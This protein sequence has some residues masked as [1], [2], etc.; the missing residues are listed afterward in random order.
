[1]LSK[2]AGESRMA[3]ESQSDWRGGFSSGHEALRLNIYSP[4]CMGVAV[5]VRYVPQRAAVICSTRSTNHTAEWENC[6]VIV[7]QR[8]PGMPWGS[9][10][11]NTF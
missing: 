9:D 11:V 1:M 3:G 7:S 4:A 2:T 10:T 6:N 8:R 5:C